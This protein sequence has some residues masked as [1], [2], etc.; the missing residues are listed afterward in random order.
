LIRNDQIV[1]SGR[2]LT[3]PKIRTFRKVQQWVNTIHASERQ[4]PQPQFRQIC[5]YFQNLH[6]P[7]TSTISQLTISDKNSNNPIAQCP[8]HGPQKNWTSLS[9]KYHDGS[10]PDK[11]AEGE[12]ELRLWPDLQRHSLSEI[13]A[14]GQNHRQSYCSMLH[15]QSD[16]YQRS[17]ILI[18][19][20][21]H[22]KEFRVL[23]LP[24][25]L[26]TDSLSEC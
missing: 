23:L 10:I 9:R 20:I 4:H 1:N 21:V 2:P 12:L 15:L 6:R 22:S 13:Y 16:G 19:R 24:I 25:L 3:K 17:T 26:L 18:S 8:G 5:L 14:E 7:Q 11:P